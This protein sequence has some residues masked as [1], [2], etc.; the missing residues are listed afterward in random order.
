MPSAEMDYSFSVSRDRLFDVIV[1]YE[2]YPDFVAGV[3]RTEVERLE[4]GLTRVTYHISMVK[5]VV[6]TLEHREDREK[7]TVEWSLVDGSFFKKN[8]GSWK[9]TPQGDGVDAEYRV[10]VEFSAPVPGFMVKKLVK[11]SLPSMM[12]SFEKQA[13]R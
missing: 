8:S 9:L 1:K 3:T 6:Y 2:D 5:D 13:S 11:G 7:G 10:D 12:K 4:A